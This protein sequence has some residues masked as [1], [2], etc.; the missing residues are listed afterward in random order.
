MRIATYRFKLLILSWAALVG[1]LGLVYF[2]H[3]NSLGR[4]IVAETEVISAIKNTG[5]SLQAQI[6]Q[7]ASGGYSLQPWQQFQNIFQHSIK[8]LS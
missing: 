3:A 4:D 5:T 1:L 7:T 2:R 6:G 8:R